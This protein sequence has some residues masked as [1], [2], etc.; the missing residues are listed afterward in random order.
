MQ[1]KVLLEHEA[2]L[3]GS[4]G[5]GRLRADAH[6]DC[7]GD[8]APLGEVL[9]CSGCTAWHGCVQSPQHLPASVFY[10]RP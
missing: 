3:W 2:A 9:G 5:L 10:M 4:A 7:S 6:R 1:R 8:L